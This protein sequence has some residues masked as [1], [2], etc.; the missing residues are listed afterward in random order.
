MAALSYKQTGYAVLECLKR[1]TDE[2]HRLK[3]ME[4]VALLEK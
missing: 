1:H 3:Q 4:I 2:S